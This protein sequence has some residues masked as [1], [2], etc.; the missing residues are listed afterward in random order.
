MIFVG[1]LSWQSIV[2]IGLGAVGLG[3]AVFTAGASIAAAGGVMAAI[4]SA[5]ATSLIVGGLGVVSDVTAI[6]SSALED[7]DPSASSTLGWI[8]LGT[9][10]AGMAVGFKGMFKGK[11]QSRFKSSRVLQDNEHELK[12][13]NGSSRNPQWHPIEHKGK[14]I[15]GAD[16]EV[17]FRHV[18]G[19]VKSIQKDMSHGTIVRK[20]I[21]V[22][23]GTHGRPHG[24]NWNAAGERID[25]LLNRNF[26]NQDLQMK[27]PGRVKVLSASTVNER[28]LTALLDSQHAHVVLGYC[29]G[30]NERA[31]RELLH[32]PMV[33]SYSTYFYK[34]L[35]KGRIKRS[36]ID[37][38]AWVWA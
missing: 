37:P 35:S 5:S 29:F 23:S 34:F 32:L 36:K 22:I 1:H 28:H 26:F 8:S 17:N 20:P 11:P 30:R 21:K 13:K 15:Y 14:M 27:I 18:E 19:I 16:Q 9:G 6:V 31:L 10:L 25:V 7:V 3:L 4:G 12:I 33:E 24:I 2:G 38:S